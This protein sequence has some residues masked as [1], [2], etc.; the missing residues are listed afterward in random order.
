MTNL[1]EAKL[2]R[3]AEICFAT[4]AL[5]TDY[6][7]WRSRT[8]RRRDRPT[9]CAVLAGQRRAGQRRPCI[10]WRTRIDGMRGAAA[11][12]RA[13][14]HAVITAPALI[15]AATRERLSPLVGRLDVCSRDEGA[16]SE[17]PWRNR[18][19]WWA[20][21][22]STTSRR[23]AGSATNV[24][25]G[26]C[27]YFSV[28][29]SFFA[30]VNMVG[31]VGRDF[32][33][34]ER[35]LS[36]SSAASTSKASRRS[37]ATRSAGTAATTRDM[38]VRDTLDLKLNVFGEFQPKLPASYRGSEFVF[39]ANI[40]PG[41]A[42]GRARRSS[43]AASTS[44]PTPW[45]TGSTPTPAELAQPAR[46]GRPAQHQRLGGACCWPASATSCAAARKILA[47]GPRHLIVKRGEYGALQFSDDEIFAVPAFPLETVV[48]P[49]G[50]G[51]CFAGGLFGSLAADGEA[52][53]AARC[54]ARSST[55]ASSLRSRWRTSVCNR[56]RTASTRDEIDAPLPPVHGDHRLPELKGSGRCAWTSP[57]CCRSSTRR[58]NLE[59]LHAELTAALAALGRSYEIV[60]VDDGS[61]RRLLRRARRIRER[62]P[63]RARGALPPQLRADGGAGGR[64]SSAPT[65]D[66]VVTLD[67]DLQNDPAD[68]PRLVAK[69]EEGYDLVIGLAA[70]PQGRLRQ[71]PPAVDDGQLDHPR[72]HQ[73]SRPRLRLHA[74]G[75]SRRHGAR[76]SPLRRD[77]PLHPGDRRRPR[78]ARS[79]RSWSTTDR[80]CAGTS[81][82]GI[83]RVVR[84][85]LDLLTVKFLSVYLDAA[86]PRVRTSRAS[87]SAASGLAMLGVARL[88]EDLLGIALAGRPILLLAILLVMTGVQLVTLGP[89]RRDAGA[90][91][92]REPG[93]AD[94]CGCGGPAARQIAAAA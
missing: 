71:P 25:G 68:I 5:A 58:D 62:R 31:V 88:R 4:L 91:L 69:L 78:R 66:I 80:A 45:T 18:F 72:H 42:G 60:Y 93:Q 11:A 75:V 22:R 14:E 48:D 19:A 79:T 24:L 34:A 57:S 59:P 46:P 54:A 7:C 36:A 77:A 81:K 8:T 28:A 94:L 53:R 70:R 1:Q 92:P 44:A 74:E 55:A 32:P 67:G 21:W 35:A 37:T 20:R 76:A 39:L 13:L 2:A 49:T 29:A 85:V 52:R 51:D 12:E 30:P 82:Y 43:S 26:A 86:D 9:S 47:M 33:E 50:A 61:T 84:V 15:P 27:S 23:R 83:S 6:D 90:H 87:C 38:N 40:Q 73:R 17:G 63:A 64:A 89:A 41:A 16:R 65:G 3:E 56:L 10:A